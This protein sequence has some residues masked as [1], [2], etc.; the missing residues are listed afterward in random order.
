MSRDIDWHV[1]DKA[2]EIT[3]SAVRGAMG[4]EGSKPA[5]Y[6]GEVFRE[7]YSALQQA[8]DVMPSKDS[9]PGF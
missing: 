7:T 3:A 5:T 4:S 2:A 8:A 1:F 6:V 9:K